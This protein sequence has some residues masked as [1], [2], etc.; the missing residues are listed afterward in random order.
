MQR[1][2]MSAALVFAGALLLSGCAAGGGSGDASGDACETI[3]AEVRDISNGAQNAL[4][5]GGDPS[6]VQSA[7]EGYSERADALGEEA[8]DDV[9]GALD[10]LVGALDEA[11][12]FAE[13]L[14]TDPEAEVDGEAV[15]E[16]QTAIQEAATEVASACAADTEN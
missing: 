13:T 9:A 3:R 5:A 15:A 4:A 6:E 1:I 16:H 7:L 10:A 8:D 14:P 11:A 12:G 2:K